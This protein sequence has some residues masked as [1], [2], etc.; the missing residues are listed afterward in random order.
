VEYKDS[1]SARSELGGG[2]MYEMSHEIDYL[3]WIFGDITWVN[4]VLRKQSNLNIDTF[5]YATVVM[6]CSNN[7]FEI[8]LKLSLDF[9]RKESRRFCEVTGD[10]G[11]LI[12]DFLKT[13]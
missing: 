4:A 9:Y 10:K 1:V 11:T 2:V 3:R 7:N 8:P 12:W 6:G 5:D 13:L